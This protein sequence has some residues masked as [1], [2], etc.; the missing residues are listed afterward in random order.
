[1][2]S[3]YTRLYC[4]ITNKKLRR[5]VLHTPFKKQPKLKWVSKKMRC[6]RKRDDS[7]SNG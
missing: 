6:N 3:L 1:M 7:V 5:R 4:I 2:N